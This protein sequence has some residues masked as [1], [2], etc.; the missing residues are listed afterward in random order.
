MKL[1]IT[2][3]SKGHATKETGKDTL[4]TPARPRMRRALT[5][6]AGRAPLLLATSLTARALRKKLRK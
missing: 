4:P 2:I 6:V 1:H 3:E 5:S